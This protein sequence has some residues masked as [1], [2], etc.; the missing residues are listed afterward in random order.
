M[1]IKAEEREESSAEFG[2]KER[3]VIGDWEGDCNLWK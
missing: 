2:E 3:D 1:E